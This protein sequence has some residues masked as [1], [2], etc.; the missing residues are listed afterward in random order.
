[1]VWTLP[2]PMLAAAVLDRHLPLGFAAEPKWDGYRALLA[3]YA[4]GQVMIRSR[5]GTDMTSAFPEVVAAAAGLPADVALDGELIVWHGGR[6][7]FERLQGRLNRKPGSAARMAAEWPAHFVAFDLLRRD[8]S[9]IRQPYALRRAALEQL[10]ADCG[11]QA[12]WS[13]CPSTTDPRL[14][15]EWLEWASVGMEGLVFKPLVSAYR[16]GRRGWAKYRTRQHSDA[17]VGAV[18][19]STDDP[20]TVLLGRHDPQGRLRYTGRSSVLSRALSADLSARLT[21]AGRHP[22]SGRTFSAGWGAKEALEVVLVVPELVVEVRADIARDSAGRW[23]HP[24]QLARFRDDLSSGD[25]PAFGAD[26]DILPH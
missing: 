4:D 26:D 24:V 21:P 15:Q 9:L 6:M 8:K 10:F 5:R 16:P 25:V 19:G 3:R 7:S 2:E 11:L 13:L 1:M 12:P 22:W 20:R 17:L 14:A 23:R 18:T